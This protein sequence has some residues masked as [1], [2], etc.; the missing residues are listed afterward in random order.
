MCQY[1]LSDLLRQITLC[2]R[3]Q[4]DENQ[5]GL[6]LGKDKRVKVEKKSPT[7]TEARM[8][9]FFV[10]IQ[11]PGCLAGKKGYH[12]RGGNAPIRP[13]VGVCLTIKAAK[14]QETR[15]V[16]GQRSYRSS[17]SSIKRKS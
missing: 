1:I 2:E 11:A 7:R 12:F 4:M 10:S 14:A 13:F 9:V 6:N 17:F 3:D 5:R 16:G 8:A 15:G